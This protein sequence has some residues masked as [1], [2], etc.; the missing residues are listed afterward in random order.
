MIFP[1]TELLPEL[2]DLPGYEGRYYVRRDG[3]VWRRYKTKDTQIIGHRKGR[4]RE[5]KLIHPAGGLKVTTMSWIMKQT[6]FREIP[7]GYVLQHVNGLENDWSF[8]NL[9]PMT[10]SELGRRINR[11]HTARSVLKMDPETGDV[12]AI[13]QSAREAGRMNFC[14]YQTI[15]DACNKVNRKRCGIA[16]DGYIYRWDE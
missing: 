1:K 10:R 2:M 3:T 8:D 14:S 12:I 13:Y 11:S 9:Q 7:E 15:L 6:Y 4:G 16:P 5:I